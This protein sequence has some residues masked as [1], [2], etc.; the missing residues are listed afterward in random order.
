M[1]SYIARNGCCWLLLGGVSLL[2]FGADHCFGADDVSTATGNGHGRPAPGA[3]RGFVRKVYHDQQ[4]NPHSYVIFV[5][6]N[7][8][9]HS[10]LPVI[11]FLN[12]FGE[13]GG[14]GLRQ[15]S[16]N[17]GVQIWENQDFFPLIALAP[18]CTTTGQ[19]SPDSLDTKWALEILD[20]TIRD[21]DA[22]EDRVS[23]TGVSAGG[24]GV[25]MVASAATDRFAA[26]VPLCGTFGADE[27]R[28]ADGKIAVW[29]FYN[30]RDNDKLVRNNREMRRQL[31]E[32]GGSPI[33]TEYPN[34]GHD[35]WNRAYRTVAL[36]EWLQ[37][38][39]RSIN[40]KS[41]RYQYLPP[42]E[43]VQSWVSLDGG[44][45]T[46]EPDGI[47]SG[48]CAAL[49]QRGRLESKTTAATFEL[50]A[51]VWMNH[52]T[53]CRIALRKESAV[54]S[55]TSYWISIPLRDVGSGG[56]IDSSG[57]SMGT[58]DPAAQGTLAAESWNEFRLR[59]ARG[60]LTIV[61]N[62]WP[63]LDVTLEH[64]TAN[65]AAVE[66]RAALATPADAT[67]GRWRYVRVRLEDAVGKTLDGE[68][69]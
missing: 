15:L 10:K 23:L 33:F 22:D 50:H 46:V 63:A 56:V 18:Q 17:F 29:N 49:G 51:D 66:F 40:R 55:D 41:T 9:P 57:R 12:G 31:I 8:Q 26:A 61:L 36:Y 45:W 37:Q 60:R 4:G 62:G 68:T 30:R 35:C 53:D 59:F 38:Q 32:H 48:T 47:L 19:W 11:M 25:W 39:R 42:E 58:L 1:K 16:N 69:P 52:L 21:Y 34:P 64:E 67:S 5:P 2:C 20:E 65:A 24:S 14:D 7:W 44:Q 54:E 13:N 28:L 43:L 27:K 3:E 6:Q